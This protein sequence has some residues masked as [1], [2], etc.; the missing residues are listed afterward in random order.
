MDEEKAKRVGQGL[1]AN[2]RIGKKGLSEG[3]IDEI[4]RHLE[5]EELV[6]VKVLRN[7][8]IQ[9]VDETAELLDNKTIGDLVE[10]RGKTVLLLYEDYEE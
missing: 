2:I 7:N 8:P 1:D 6:K 5:N 4:D 3:L 10:V 9:D